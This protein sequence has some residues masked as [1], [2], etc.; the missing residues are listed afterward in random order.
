[1]LCIRDDIQVLRNKASD[2]EHAAKFAIDD[3]S[4]AIN[5]KRAKLY[6][7]LIDEAELTL[8][9]SQLGKWRAQK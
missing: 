6:R 2:C 8:R 3:D 1:M 7:E 5:H 4:R 9:Q